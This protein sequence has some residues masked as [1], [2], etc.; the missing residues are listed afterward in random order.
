MTKENGLPFGE[1]PLMS[2]PGR[3]LLP[4]HGIRDGDRPFADEIEFAFACAI[5]HARQ[6]VGNHSEARHSAKT[7]L[8]DE[9]I[10]AIHV[11][12]KLAVPSTLQCVF[13]LPCSVKRVLH[14]PDGRDTRVHHGDVV[15][16][17]S[18]RLV[19]QPLNQFLAIGSVKNIV[20]VVF[21]AR[22]AHACRD[23]HQV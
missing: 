16:E 6:V 14:G 17:V 18:E 8:P 7:V 20:K 4:C 12:Q 3:H 10:I 9:G 2:E 1:S 21:A 11:T 5:T 15:L 23:S 19:M 13:D 22:L